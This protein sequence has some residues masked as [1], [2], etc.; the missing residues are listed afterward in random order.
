MVANGWVCFLH[1]VSSPWLQL[2][3]TAAPRFM[4]MAQAIGFLKLMWENW[5]SACLNPTHC[6]YLERDESVDRISLSFILP[7]L[8]KWVH[9]K[10]MNKKGTKIAMLE[11]LVEVLMRVAFLM[12]TLWSKWAKMSFNHVLRPS[13]ISVG[14]MCSFYLMFNLTFFSMRV[15]L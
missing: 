2:P 1:S 9:W 15:R 7:L 3:A 4:E 5:V 10:W 13:V 14:C 11:A 12:K 8:S 6:E